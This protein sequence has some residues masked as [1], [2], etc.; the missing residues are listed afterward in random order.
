MHFSLF[1][2]CL[3][4]PNAIVA[5]L[6]GLWAPLV[7]AQTEP[8]PLQPIE[9]EF[10]AVAAEQVAEISANLDAAQEMQGM[11]AGREGVALELV[12][13]RITRYRVDAL[14]AVTSLA[15]DVAAKS[16]AGYDVSQWLPLLRGYLDTLPDAI[17]AAARPAGQDKVF[18][19]VSASV[20]E[21]AM[22]DEQLFYD[23]KLYDDSSWALKRG[24]EA[25]ERL[26]LDMSENR[27][28]LEKRVSDLMGSASVYLDRS[29]LAVENIRAAA[30]AL[31]EDPELKAK[32]Q[33][34]ENRVKRVAAVME[35]NVPL[36]AFL[37]VPATAYKRQI[38]STTGK[39]SAEALDTEVVASLF[40]D[41]GADVMEAIRSKGPSFL[42]ELFIFGLIIF[43]F[44][45]LAGFVRSLVQ[46]TLSSSRVQASNLLQRMATAA[47]YNIVIVIG[48]LIALS[49]VGISLGPLLTG[50]GIAGFIVGFALQDSLSNFASGMLILLYRPYDVGDTVEV[51]GVFGKVE[52]MSLVNTTILTLD[53]Q[54]L[55]VPNNKIWQDVIKN[56]T[57]QNL[58]RVDLVFGIAYDQ[59]LDVVERVLH[60]VVAADDRVLEDPELNIRVHELADSSVNFIVRP[61]V[62]TDDY[63]DV[64]WDL[65]KAVKQRFDAEGISIPFPQRDV[66]L[67]AGDT[68]AAPTVTDMAGGKS[69]THAIDNDAVSTEEDG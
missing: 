60:E 17:E 11:L 49:Q 20:V 55:I 3:L 45:K 65:T 9:A 66:H 35:N 2:A 32:L 54:T 21:L 38:V 4:R 43:L 42:L 26:E 31:P 69:Q 58:R 48:I 10:A 50:L 64:Y 41:W 13:A 6:A 46:R 61:W 14:N 56:L 63:W 8:K 51:S 47:S 29:A 7:S 53:N 18:P 23:A 67:F 37:E 1:R 40:E 44:V 39:V 59:D 30:R 33:L 25:G 27:A 28:Y 24:I 12:K 19:E 5:I 36:L 22:F 68:A 62:K 34:A 52:A 15:A 16:E 57:F